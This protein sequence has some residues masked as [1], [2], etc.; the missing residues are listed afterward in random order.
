DEAVLR[1]TFEP[2]KHELAGEV[3]C[4]R[5]QDEGEQRLWRLSTAGSSP[6]RTEGEHDAN[7]ALTKQRTAQLDYTKTFAARGKLETGYKGNARW[8]DRNFA[9]EKDSLGSGSWTRSPLSNAFQFDE[10]VNAAYA[11]LSQGV[12]K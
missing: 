2:Q 9:V 6:V 12:G 8:F 7:D 11:V 10:R 1:R 5:S 4:N 3:R